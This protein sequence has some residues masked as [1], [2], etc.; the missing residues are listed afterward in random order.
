MRFDEHE[1]KKRLPSPLL[2]FRCLIQ[3]L[4]LET[5]PVRFFLLLEEFVQKGE[6]FVDDF[7]F[8]DG[9]S[10]GFYHFFGPWRA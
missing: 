5:R 1:A 4:G 3:D 9:I 7:F 10:F 2:I 8:V 6:V